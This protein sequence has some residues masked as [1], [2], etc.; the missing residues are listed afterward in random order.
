M[1]G[2]IPGTTIV[3]TSL[4]YG[5]WTDAEY[6]QAFGDELA[7]RVITHN[8][9]SE[10]PEESGTPSGPSLANDTATPTGNPGGEGAVN[11]PAGGITGEA[12][13]AT[14]MAELFASLGPE[15]VARFM[16]SAQGKATE[17]ATRAEDG[18]NPLDEGGLD[19]ASFQDQINAMNATGASQS[20]VAP[21]DEVEV[22]GVR[23]NPY[24]QTLT[25][26]MASV[27]PGLEGAQPK[28]S[29]GAIMQYCAAQLDN[30]ASLKTIPPQFGGQLALDNV[31][32]PEM[33]ENGLLGLRQPTN[34]YEED[35]FS[36]QGRLQGG[37]LHPPTASLAQRMSV[38]NHSRS[39]V[40]GLLAP[41]SG[42]SGLH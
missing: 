17:E 2:R 36:P 9:S 18:P 28:G 12:G 30:G 42:T 11:A 24:P 19:S 40:R 15:W 5:N 33:N 1:E 41:P 20:S 10:P 4:K 14:Q 26:A 34:A 37:L 6:A 32:Q 3:D 22:T 16:N 8:N 29:F 39:P 35:V 21:F 23:Q 27:R 38:S 13:P 31:L 25:Y 7:A